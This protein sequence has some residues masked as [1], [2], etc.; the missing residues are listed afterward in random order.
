MNKIMCG[1]YIIK[2]MVNNKV[3]IGQSVN[4]D[5]RW[6][7]HINA[8]DNHSHY[9]YHLQAAWDKYGKDA[10]VFDVVEL[11]GKERLD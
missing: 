10:F 8:L 1:I 11:C 9:N 5:K 6:Y 4:I 2:N 7:D 3:Y